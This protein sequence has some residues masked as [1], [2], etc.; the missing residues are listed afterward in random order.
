[1]RSR[2]RV[3]REKALRCAIVRGRHGE[4]I[5]DGRTHTGT[6]TVFATSGPRRPCS[7]RRRHAR[8]VHAARA[9]V[10]GVHVGRRSKRSANSWGV[11]CGGLRGIVFFAERRTSQRGSTSCSTTARRPVVVMIC[12]DLCLSLR[13]DLTDYIR[14]YFAT[15]F[16]PPL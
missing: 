7:C 4:C 14:C 11:C 16:E 9:A 15:A 5:V 6:P 10:L 8:T 12:V 13:E 3:P 1:M 2:M